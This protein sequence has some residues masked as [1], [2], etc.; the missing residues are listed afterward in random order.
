MN[1]LEER[2]VVTIM[3][4]GKLVEL[5]RIPNQFVYI[6][7]EVDGSS[8]TTDCEVLQTNYHLQ[9]LKSAGYKVLHVRV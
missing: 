4:G 5:S 8:G 9:Q 1:L 7:W 3:V 6:D 2:D